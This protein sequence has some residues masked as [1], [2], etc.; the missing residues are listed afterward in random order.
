MLEY[1]RHLALVRPPSVDPII[2]HTY[3]SMQSETASFLCSNEKGVQ[4]S[5]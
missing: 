1:K 5:R 3:Y 2:W 4:G